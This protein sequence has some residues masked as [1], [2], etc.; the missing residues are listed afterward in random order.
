LL[1][2]L[3]SLLFVG[4]VLNV[5]NNIEL[6]GTRMAV[7]SCLAFAT[8]TTIAHLADWKLMPERKDGAPAKH[9]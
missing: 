6:G 4:C 5:S 3:L 1:L 2:L 9:H 7:G 8:F